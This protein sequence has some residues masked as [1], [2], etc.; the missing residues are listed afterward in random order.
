MHN[1]QL[2]IASIALTKLE[3]HL[4]IYHIF[5]KLG[6]LSVFSSIVKSGFD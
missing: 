6:V 5:A 2:A 3:N 4:E 1:N